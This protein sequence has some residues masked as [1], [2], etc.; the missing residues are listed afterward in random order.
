MDWNWVR[1]DIP[2]FERP[3]GRTGRGLEFAERLDRLVVGPADA[4]FVA[5]DFFDLVRES[6][7]VVDF[8]W[9]REGVVFE[10]GDAEETPP[11]M[12]EQLD[13]LRLGFRLGVPLVAEVG[14]ELV[15]GFGGFAG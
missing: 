1:I 11:V 5:G 12:G 8:E 3:R 9:A 4:D 2:D 13:L 15:E 6:E 10:S 7:L 14:E